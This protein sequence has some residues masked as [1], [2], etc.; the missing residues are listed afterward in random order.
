M[1]HEAS[2]MLIAGPV[3]KVYRTGIAES[4]IHAEYGQGRYTAGQHR[5]SDPKHQYCGDCTILDKI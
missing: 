1:Q 4:N 2:R 3:E 5:S